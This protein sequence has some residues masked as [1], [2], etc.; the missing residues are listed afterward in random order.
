[1]TPVP[2]TPPEYVVADATLNL[3]RMSVTLLRDHAT[4]EIPLFSFVLGRPSGAIRAIRG[5]QGYKG[6][7]DQ[8]VVLTK[9]LF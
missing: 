6:Y 4:E 3:A 8:L 2:T 1:M 7:S 5:Y 9:S